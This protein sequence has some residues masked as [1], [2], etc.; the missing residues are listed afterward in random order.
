MACNTDDKLMEPI[1][2]V[3][4]G[5]R[6]PGESHSSDSFWDLLS[7]GRDGWRTMPKHRFNLDGYYHPDGARAGSV[8]V[9]GSHFLSGEYEKSA[10][11]FDAPFFN[12]T[13]SEVEGSDPQH[14]H[15]LE[16]S[17]EAL[18]N[19]GIPMQSVI[20]S[21][22]S[23]YVG[24][25]TRDWEAKGGRDPYTGPFY[26][27][28]GNGMSM[29]ANR[30]SWFYDMRGP[31]MT[32]DTAC[33]S[34]LYAVHL[35][36][37][38]LRTGE[39]KMAIAGGTNIIC[40][41]CYMRDLTTMGFLS[42]DGRCHSF[43]HR[44]NGYGRGDGIGAVVLKTISQALKDGDTIRAVIRN[45]GLGQD[46][47]TPGITMPA[48]EAQADL[49]RLVY[50]N[51][52]LTMDQ[53]AYFEAH[54]TGT[55][56]GD[57]YEL[58][59]LG[60]T[61]GKTREPTNP[62]Y[63]GSVKANIGHLEGGAGIAGLIK[64]ALVVERGQIPPLAD[65]EKVNP[66]LKLDEWK[67]AL[68]LKLTP[69][70][71]SGVRRASVNC[72]GYGG[73]NSHVIID[74]AYHFLQEHGLKGHHQT[75]LGPHD[76][77]EISDGSDSGFS[78]AAPSTPADNTDREL[79]RPLLMVLSSVDQAGL[80]RSAAALT[81]FISQ[82]ADREA[83]D[84]QLETASAGVD[85][86][87]FLP[88]LAYTLSHRRST[89]DHR[90]FVVAR[91]V[92]ELQA[93]LSA[94]LSKLRRSAKNSNVFFVFT[95]QGAQWATMGKSL[96]A[97]DTYRRSL[98]R[99]QAQLSRLGCAWN[100]VSE[101]CAPKGQS[102]IDQ[103]EFSQ[104]L[105]TAL[106]VALVDLLEEWN[107]RPKSVVGHSSGEIA[108]SYAAGFLTH[109]QAV[110]V[111]YC[112]GLFS[113]DVNRRL[114]DKRGAMMAVGLSEADV[115]PYLDQVPKESVV[116]ACVNSPNS[117]T[118]SGDEPSINVLEKTLQ[119]ASVFARKLRVTTAYHS[120]HMR[121][122]ADDYLAA[123]DDI[124]Q[125]TE[126]P[127]AT[128]FSSVTGG[129]VLKAVDVDASY[130]VKNMLGCV[131]FSDAVQA[132]LTQP[133]N[134]N[135][136]GR[137]RAPVVYSAMVE[138][139]PA[140]ALKG[141]LLQILNATDGRLASSLPYTALLSR[142]VDGG[143]SA[144]AA[145]GKLW[146]SGLP[147][148]LHRINFPTEPEQPLQSLACLPP[149][150][151][152]H[153]VYEHESTYGKTVL[154]RAKPRTD[155]LG[156]VDETADESEPRWHN[157]IRLTEQPWLGDHRVQNMVL[158]P[159]AA[160]V[161][162]AIE[163]AR[164]LQD[165]SRTL[166]AVE[167]RDIAFKK[168][169]VIPAGDAAAETAIHLKPEK[170]PSSDETAWSFSVFSKTGEDP[171]NEMCTGS[172]SLLYSGEDYG[173]SVRQWTSE[174]SLY[175]DIRKRACRVVKAATFYKLFDDK[176][177]LQYGPLHRNVTEATAGF[178][179][180]YGVVTIPDT[181]SV[182]PS[183]FEY[184]HL[185]HPATLDSIFHMQA[186]GYLHSLSG[187]ESLVPISI[188][189]IYVA[190]NAPTEAG[191]QLRGYSKG[192]QSSSGDTVGDIVL[193]DD[194]WQ[195]PKVIVRGFLS[196]DISAAA[197][198][199]AS[200]I[201][202]APRKCTRLDY[203]PLHPE[204]SSGS[205]A[206][207]DDG[208][209]LASPASRLDQLIVLHA[210]TESLDLPL[211]VAEI[212]ARLATSCEH[213]VQ[214]HP[215]QVTFGE[216]S[217]IKDKTVLS[218]L[219][220]EESFVDG[221]SEKQFSWLRDL[222]STAETI[223]WVTRG[224]DVGSPE[225]IK[226]SATNGLLRT[227]RVEKPQLRLFQLDLDTTSAL[228]S[229]TSIDLI[230]D[231]FETSVLSTAKA[232]EQEF[233][234]IG[235]K[236]HVP[237]LVTDESFHAEL[238]SG[239]TNSAPILQA[240]T[241]MPYPVRA[242]VSQGGRSLCFVKDDQYEAEL[243]E[244]EVEVAPCVT[245][246]DA[247]AFEA[248]L[249]L[250]R[251]A[252]GTITAAGAAVKDYSVGEKV[253][254]CA[255][256]CLRT[257][258]RVKSSFVRKQPDFI[259]DAVAV[260]LPT[261]LTLAWLSLLELGFLKT[262]ESV[263]IAA[264]PDATTGAMI[265]LAQ[266]LGAKVYASFTTAYHHRWL[267]EQIGLE[268]EQVIKADRG[269]NFKETLLRR[270]KGKGVDVV[271][272]SNAHQSFNVLAPFGRCVCLGSNQTL[273][274]TAQL[275]L[276]VSIHNLDIEHFRAAA[277]DR[278]ARAYQSAWS[279]ASKGVFHTLPPKRA[280]SLADFA[281]QTNLPDAVKAPGGVAVTVDPAS[282]VWTLPP[283][284]AVLHLDAEATY[285]LAGGLGGIGRSIA[286]TMFAAG[287]RKISFI[288]RSGA[289]TEEAKKLLSSLQ[290]RGCVAKAYAV[291]VSSSSAVEAFVQASIERGESIKGV[292]QAAM[293]LQDSVFDN[294]TFEQWTRSTAPKI[295]GSWNLHQH[296][297]RDM[298]F[299]IMLSSMAGIIGNPGQA[300]YSAAGTY[301]DALSV[302][303][304]KQGLN[305]TTIDLG[306]VSDVGYIAENPEQ[307]ERLRYLKPLFISER[308]LRLLLSAAMLGKTM[309]G[310]DVPPQVVT[311]VG[312]ELMQ[313]GSI[314]SAMAADLKY[315][316]LHG[317]SGN[318]AGDA[319]EDEA[320]QEALKTA[321][322]LQTAT[323]FVEAVFASNIAKAT[324]ME[325]EDVDLDRP[326]HAYG[327]DSLAAVEVRNMIYRKFKSD[328]SVFDLLS[329]LALHKLAIRVVAKSKLVK[330]E[331]QVVAQEE[332]AE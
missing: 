162:Q 317:S 209:E 4:M 3:G 307:F 276:G 301:Q 219:E 122:I 246:L 205:S 54:G 68:P 164:T 81:D 303:R 240:L 86:E 208:V 311:G 108:A 244:D 282:N 272:T 171:W 25:F 132:L 157:Y 121:V 288:S 103:P 5:M 313:D 95:G 193:S 327:V 200:A 173:E 56:I 66:R 98:E 12:I 248:G 181:K 299:F 304:R 314:G 53:T 330:N 308:D 127:K 43:D 141:P 178:G 16:V 165:A 259:G 305:S 167:V 306:I 62:L 287:A 198:S 79:S 129:T 189:K 310:N 7:K 139:G 64:A 146:A 47:R 284:P 197:P 263:L 325:P 229:D 163:A 133:A 100:L 32:I 225:T 90:T 255:A 220:A 142:N 289:K 166:K 113:A 201:D 297:P 76:I 23:V 6:F 228:Y 264:E 194:A 309:D 65:F 312:K 105:C 258:L 298:D 320:A 96:L 46:G 153:K 52:G 94:P 128:M 97:F 110:K 101:L 77:P 226:F 315:S 237:R 140:E 119:D 159:G 118:L 294:M 223:L 120:P 151:W 24:C 192:T 41:P 199:S 211:V 89:F 91:S 213:I 190:A 260:T 222:A 285:V 33:S 35:A 319:G 10:K 238:K 31:S 73:A 22:T 126:P 28:T 275:A 224:A 186:L 88:D 323:E 117:V 212:S 44:A 321:T 293:V 30:V 80:G 124:Q 242:I 239:A 295:Q 106:Q 184:P 204:E 93:Q 265:Y 49:I 241:A 137:R 266:H 177:N 182:M 279:L 112:R 27:A 277:P 8:F 195:E 83:Q 61:F 154:R 131:R 147:I 130:W 48:P 256:S 332:N 169:L 125:S 82:Q 42:P 15:M 18:E 296:F 111:A 160:M 262:G 316:S 145:A 114:G 185:I 63:V 196:R 78:S 1:A 149:Y 29:L 230:V 249:S 40:D 143:Q 58:S 21:D 55:P 20:G 329:T 85:M 217:N 60:A 206:Q 75:I 179:E 203:V 234:Q 233:V 202:N 92:S 170:V 271:V 13:A 134:P 67:V 235:D 250:G 14:L 302:H 215:E 39:A 300:N 324:G 286:E 290:Q 176:M 72:F 261:A 254:V 267:V 115:K 70:P 328:I 2:I 109:E 252:V 74:D 174:S 278:V 9:K 87:S 107:L 270:N 273:S 281:A 247:A 251:D 57:P 148:D 322:S 156:F 45:T 102:H 158:Y 214:M 191:T 221:W 26:A 84:K 245:M 175:D 135:A 280:L 38:S 99:A 37:Q 236:L 123:M 231:A 253:L 331:V 283:P 180:G 326:M 69:W 268:E 50:K 292:V 168:G 172:V 104:P 269:D 34:S 207:S 71:V 17:Y 155:L 116:I 232:V 161:V 11:Q 318:D 218:L 152:N 144:L 136:K 243:A 291:D 187:D 183:Q 274:S 36:C 150:K 138:V 227:I 59:A 216:K 188:D 210:S 257:R 19:A 51:A